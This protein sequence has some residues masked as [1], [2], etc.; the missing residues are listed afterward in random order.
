MFVNLYVHVLGMINVVYFNVHVQPVQIITQ[1]TVVYV[2]V[3][4][5]VIVMVEVLAHHLFVQSHTNEMVFY[6]MINVVINIMVLALFV[7]NIVQ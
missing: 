5:F 4:I 7:G 2:D 1:I 6:V 3:F